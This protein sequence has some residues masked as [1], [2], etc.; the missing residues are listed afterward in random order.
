[1]FVC[2]DRGGGGRQLFFSVGLKLA[3]FRELKMNWGGLCRALKNSLNPFRH[4]IIMTCHT[5]ENLVMNLLI[6]SPPITLPNKRNRDTLV[7][8]AF[9]RA[10]LIRRY[11]MKQVPESMSVDG[12]Y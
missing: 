4:F 7:A 8:N 6:S 9:Q 10:S 5:R 11:I 2:G 12:F 3:N 1:M